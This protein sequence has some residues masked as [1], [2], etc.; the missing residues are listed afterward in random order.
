MT[1]VGQRYLVC[2]DIADPK[3]LRRMFKK[4]KGFGEALQYSVFVCDL[5]PVQRVRLE[6]VI[7]EIINQREDRVVI[8]D[9]GPA[10]GRG[11]ESIQQ[12]GRSTV[13]PGRAKA[14]VV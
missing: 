7:L 9:V 5:S 13:L 14:A 3:R 8:V 2:Y 12:I 1:G 10:G 4:M 11:S 6:E